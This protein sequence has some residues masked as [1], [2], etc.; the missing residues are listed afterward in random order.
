M[1][2]GMVLLVLELICMCWYVRIYVHRC[3]CVY[4][5]FVIM[6]GIYGAFAILH[7]IS[8]IFMYIYVSTHAFVYMHIKSVMSHI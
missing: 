2:Y 1:E 3:V 4:L 6:H 8:V 7:G 5:T